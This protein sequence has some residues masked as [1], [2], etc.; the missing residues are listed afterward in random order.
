MRGEGAAMRTGTRPA[1]VAAGVYRV[2]RGTGKSNVYLVRS[3]SS[4]VLIDAGWAHQGALIK[5][6]AEMV[7]GVDT[8]PAAI[9]LTHLHPD[10]AGSAAELAQAWNVPVYV[11]PDELPPPGGK[12]A[13]TD[14]IGRVIEPF[15]RFLP[16]GDFGA[17]LRIAAAFDPGA[18][19]PGLPGWQCIPT[20]RAHAWPCQL[21]PRGRRGADQR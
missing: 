13:Y 8:P 5:S 2:V 3:G 4:W 19:V 10:H 21:L 18:G 11:H 1:E 16:A 9:V 15:A 20:P 7:F 6:S 14:P 17:C 12:L